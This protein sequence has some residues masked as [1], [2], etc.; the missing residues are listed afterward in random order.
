MH[1]YTSQGNLLN[2]LFFWSSSELG[3]PAV[4]YPLVPSSFVEELLFWAVIFEFPEKI[5]TL[6]LKM[7]P[8]N[9]YKVLE[10]TL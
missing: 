9:T 8:D 3:N 10:P 6:L 5:V 7:L 1:V 4:A 2:L